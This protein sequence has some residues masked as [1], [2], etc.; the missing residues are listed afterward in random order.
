MQL[1][2][3]HQG[4]PPP[5][6]AEA[7]RPGHRLGARQDLVQGAQGPRLPPGVQAQPDLRGRPDAAGPPR[8]QAG[9]LQRRVQ[10]GIRHRQPGRPRGQLRRRA[11][12]STRRPSGPRGWSRATTSTASR[13]WAT[14]TLTKP[15]EVHAT[16]FS[17]SAAAKIAAAGGKTVAV[18]YD[19]RGR[20]GHAQSRGD[21]R[22][23]RAAAVRDDRGDRRSALRR[24]PI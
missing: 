20:P 12:S 24:C 13:S 17:E 1:H 16:K 4:D 18:P 9:L 7:G 8:P 5:Q 15:L 10:E 6:A 3:V 21:R 23:V 11:P 19:R 22:R 14:A 2:D